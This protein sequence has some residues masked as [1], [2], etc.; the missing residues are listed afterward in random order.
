MDPVEIRVARWIRKRRESLRWTVEDLADVS[1]CSRA[2]VLAVESGVGTTRI[3]NVSALIESL[4]G[5]LEVGDG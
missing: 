5:R 4:G 2:V 1:G 3:A